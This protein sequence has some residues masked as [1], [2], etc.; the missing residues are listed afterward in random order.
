MSCD[1]SILSGQWMGRDINSSLWYISNRKKNLKL[2]FHIDPTMQ[3]SGHWFDFCFDFFIVLK[4]KR[5][6]N[7]FV[8]LCSGNPECFMKFL[9]IIYICL[10]Y[11]NCFDLAKFDCIIR[12]VD[13][14]DFFEICWNF[15]LNLVAASDAL[16]LWLLMNGEEAT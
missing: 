9:I 14:L 3:T 10:L 8:L 5:M 15:F 6:T 7:V 16:V 11:A 4:L 12:V 1:I 13:F 2:K